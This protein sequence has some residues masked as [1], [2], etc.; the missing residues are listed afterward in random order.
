MN[1]NAAH[2]H[3][4]SVGVGPPLVLLHGFAMH[5]GLFAPVLT[6]LAARRRAYVADLPG[7]GYSAPPH[8][9]T[10]HAIV[11]AIDAALREIEGPLDVVGWSL[12]GLVAMAWA[13]RYPQRLRRIVLV[14]S[15]PRFVAGPDWSHAI[16]RETLERFG[17]EL[18][19]AYEPTLKRFLALQVQGSDQGR[20]ILATLRSR[21]FERGRPAPETLS[22]SL[23]LLEQTDLRS[24]VARIAHPALV[25]CGD[26]DAL[27][28]LDAGTWLARALPHGERSVIEG[29]AHVPFLSHRDAFLAATMPF[30]HAR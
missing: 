14:A 17:D 23:R 25:L 9:Y 13:V 12:G 20:A 2:V 30:I 1:A 6:Q 10:L 19:V 27:I 16:A 18:H 15:T 21:L 3:V 28:P 22:G 29:A 4:E 11:D 8:E 24:A 5:G 7:H 26:R